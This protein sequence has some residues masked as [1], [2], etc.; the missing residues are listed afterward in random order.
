MT[1]LENIL[2]MEKFVLSAMQIRAGEC[3]PLVAADLNPDDF[4]RPQ[5]RLV[6][7]AT[8]KLYAEGTPPNVLSLKD[9]LNRIGKLEAV[10]IEFL[11]FLMEYANTTAYVPAYCKAIKDTANLRRAQAA[12][13]KIAQDAASGK[14]SVNEISA[15]FKAASSALTS[16]QSQFKMST[17]KNCLADYF[18]PELERLSKIP[19]ISTGFANIDEKQILQPGLVFIGAEPALGKTDFVWQLLE[20]MARGGCR[21]IYASYEMSKMAM[22]RRI[23]ARHIFNHNPFSVL[24]ASNLPDNFKYAEHAA[25][26]IKAVNYLRDEELDLQ[27]LELYDQNVDS[28]IRLLSP[29]CSGDRQPVIAIDYLQNLAAVTNPDNPKVAVDEC[30]RKLKSFQNDT[31][32]LLFLVSSFNRANYRIPVGYGSFKE[33]GSVEYFADVLWGLQLHVVNLLDGKETAVELAQIIHDAFKLHPRQIQLR[34]IKNR[35]GSLY[36]AFFHYYSAHSYF[37][38]CTE[39]DFINDQIPAN[40]EDGSSVTGNDSNNEIIE[41]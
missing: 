39:L 4:Y 18:L 2:E 23:A 24:T 38:P 26:I 7:N 10:G 5:H 11:Y 9:E 19:H 40:V 16:P 36:D 17:L 28:L 14:L 37:A 34:C 35:T 29:L 20:Q 15:Q 31:G 22:L 33:S 25:E 1:T 12:A 13:E 8:L 21:C 32:A 6:F 3:V 41:K 27:I 30:L